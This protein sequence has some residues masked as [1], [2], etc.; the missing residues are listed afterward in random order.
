MAV[1]LEAFPKMS[2]DLLVKTG[3]CSAIFDFGYKY[4]G[5]ERELLTATADISTSKAAVLQLTD[6]A[7]HWHPETSNLIARCRCVINVPLFL[8][9]E[10]GLAA[11]NGG[12]LGVA[13]M[14]MTPDASQRGVTP[15]GTITS[16]STGP[17]EISGEIVFPPKELRGTLIIQTV[18]YL[19]ERGNPVGRERYQAHQTGT[20]LGVLD[21]TRIIIDGNG[22]LFPV[23]EISSP[24]EPLWWVRCEWNDPLE[25]PFT[26]DNFCIYLNTAHKDYAA[27]NVN[28]GL[29]NSP[30]LFEI[31]CSALQMLMMKVLGDETAR[32]A[33]IQG[34][35]IQEGS[36]SSMVNYFL[37]TFGVSYDPGNPESLAIDLRKAMMKM[38]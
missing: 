5:E 23:H 27:L 16:D 4:Q 26:D 12:I 37:H 13:L 6:Q 25:D 36:V 24:N 10:D 18:L 22:S 31:I 34:N 20:L 11:K 29:K 15:I 9:G 32:E 28:E 38:I 8:F 17:L 3:Y 7:C 21:E 33:T 14:W 35:G 19:K 2:R 1:I 30:L